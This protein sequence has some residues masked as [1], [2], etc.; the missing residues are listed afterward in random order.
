MTRLNQQYAHSAHLSLFQSDETGAAGFNLHGDLAPLACFAVKYPNKRAGPAVAVAF[1]L[2]QSIIMPIFTNAHI[3]LPGSILHGGAVEVSQGR[4][5]GIRRGGDVDGVDLQGRYLLPGLVDVHTHPRL[6]DGLALHRLRALC[7]HLRGAGVAAFLFA[8]SNVPTAKLAGTASQIARNIAALG[9]GRACVGIHLEG[10]YVEEE[11]RGGFQQDA[12]ARPGDFPL[13]TLLK[14]CRGW[15]RYL[16]VSPGLPGAARLIAEARERDLAVSIGHTVAGREALLAA[17]DAGAQAICHT[18]NA[19]PLQH[20]KEPGVLAPTVDLLG[21]A[22]RELLCEAICDGIHVDPLLVRVLLEAKGGDGVCLVTDSVLGGAEAEEG[23]EITAGNTHYRI[24]GG[25]ARLPDGTLAG[26]TLTMAR[27]LRNF[28]EFTG[29]GLPEAVRAAALTPARLVGIDHD[30]GSIAPGKRAIFCVLDTGLNLDRALCRRVNG[31]ADAQDAPPTLSSDGIRIQIKR[32]DE[33]SRAHRDIVSE[34]ADEVFGADMDR[35]IWAEPDWHLLVRHYSR[36]VS[37]LALL[38]RQVRV[39]GDTLTVGG[40]GTVMT[41]RPWR[42]QGLASMALR[43]AERFIAEALCADFGL[44]FCAPEMVPF[45]A[46]SGWVEVTGPVHVE[47]P[48]GKRV[49]PERTMVF[50]CSRRAWPGGP[51]ELCNPPW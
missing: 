17:L 27:A 20:W 44:L 5:V 6:E 7:D 51:V 41:P 19:S 23:E 13:D 14:A 43:R 11:G 35:F 45:Y 30:Y 26:S 32:K 28:V 16:N 48:E 3:V 40:V 1:R 47:Q 34:W 50:P 37:H 21:L 38:R 10:P 24:T 49:W 42:G 18:F 12:I 15:A 31:V 22:S 29:C 46:R 4:I 25:A 9:D 33:L 8:P 36:V 39:N 2:Q